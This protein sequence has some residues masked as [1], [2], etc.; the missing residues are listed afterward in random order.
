MACVETG[1]IHLGSSILHHTDG[2]ET[3]PVGARGNTRAA[4][5]MHAYKHTNKDRHTQ[6]VRHRYTMHI[7]TCNRAVLWMKTL[8]K[9]KFILYISFLT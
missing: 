1:H 3:K 6:I 9:R 7:K 5:R 4:L 2:W 8:K